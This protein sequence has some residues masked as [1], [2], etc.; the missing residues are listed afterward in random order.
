MQIIWVSSKALGTPNDQRCKVVKVLPKLQVHVQRCGD[1]RHQIID[2]WD[3]I[4]VEIGS[5]KTSYSIF[6]E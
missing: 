2:A 1:S 6:R 5:G 3:I 4:G